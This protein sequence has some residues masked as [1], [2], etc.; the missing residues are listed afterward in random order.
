MRVACSRAAAADALGVIGG[1]A[2]LGQPAGG[3]VGQV[4]VDAA[5]SQPGPQQFELDP[6]DLAQVF[7]AES[8][9]DNDV[10]DSVDEL[11]PEVAADH[12]HDALFDGFV[13]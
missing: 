12:V 9:E 2:V 6:D 10:V 8:V 4:E 5:G 11:R 7:A 3:F 13:G 1:E